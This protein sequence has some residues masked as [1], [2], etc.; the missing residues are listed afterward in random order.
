MEKR[1]LLDDA[2]YAD[3]LVRLENLN[4]DSEP[5]WGTMTVGQML[6]HCCDVQDVGNGNDLQSS[7]FIAKMLKGVIKKMILNEK[8]FPHNSRTHPQFVQT[9]PAE[10]DKQKSRMVASMETFRANGPRPD[11]HPLFGMMTNDEW[12]W[13]YYKHL[14]HHL[15][16]FGV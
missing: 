4:A 15:H 2:A 14:D 13:M 6:S 1:S 7:G 11:G 5:E 12:G 9:E 16:Q 8:P 10:F 3:L